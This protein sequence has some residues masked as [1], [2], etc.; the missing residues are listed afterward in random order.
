MNTEYQISGPKN[1]KLELGGQTEARYVPRVPR[2][3]IYS[4]KNGKMERGGQTKN[5]ISDTKK[6][7]SE[8]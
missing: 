1:G 6:G 7:E 4:A 3:R 5:E 2:Y 8:L